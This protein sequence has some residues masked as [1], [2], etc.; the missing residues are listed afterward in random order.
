M[1]K[2]KTHPALLVTGWTG[3]QI[4][5]RK[6]MVILE[7]IISYTDTL[8]SPATDQKSAFEVFGGTGEA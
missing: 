6:D 7:S 1:H 2:F 4:K 3:L 8:D 5:I